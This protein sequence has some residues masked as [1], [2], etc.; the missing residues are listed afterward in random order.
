MYSLYHV[1]KRLEYEGRTGNGSGCVW[2]LEKCRKTCA[3]VFPHISDRGYL[4]A[5]KQ[6]Y[7]L[8]NKKLNVFVPRFAFFECSCFND[9]L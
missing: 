9:L 7:T 2:K 8:F 1:S 6:K 4:L 5:L 3:F